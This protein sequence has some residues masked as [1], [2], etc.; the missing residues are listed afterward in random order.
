MKFHSFSFSGDGMSYFNGMKFTTSD[1]DNDKHG[2]INCA[3][4]SYFNGGW[5]YNKCW[6]GNEAILNGHYTHR[7]NPYQG[8]I[9]KSFKKTS[10]KKSTMKI[11]KV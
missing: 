2:H 10:L 5:W 7:N 6:T 3:N 4:Y 11:R 8:I 1:Q 9:Y